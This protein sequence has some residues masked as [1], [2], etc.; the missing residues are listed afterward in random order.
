MVDWELV[1]I[2]V[3]AEY[4]DSKEEIFGANNIF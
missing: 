4:E 3:L 2:A 1:R